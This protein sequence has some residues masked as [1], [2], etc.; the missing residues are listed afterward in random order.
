MRSSTSSGYISVSTSYEFKIINALF[1]WWK[2]YLSFIPTPPNSVQQS[3]TSFLGGFMF[4]RWQA[5]LVLEVF[6]V[7]PVDLTTSTRRTYLLR[8]SKQTKNALCGR[9][10]K[11]RFIWTVKWMAVV[12]KLSDF[13]KTLQSTSTWIHL[14]YLTF[15]YSFGYKILDSIC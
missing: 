11:Q 3:S 14:Y 6:T 4:H 9:W 13:N 1:D 5:C 7:V 15:N 2:C 10:V 12:T 8:V